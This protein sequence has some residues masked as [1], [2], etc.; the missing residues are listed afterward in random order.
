M[1]MAIYARE[2]HWSASRTVAQTKSQHLIFL[3]DTEWSVHVG[4]PWSHPALGPQLANEGLVPISPKGLCLR[5]C[6]VN[7]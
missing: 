5:Y 6:N 7:W 2:A 1:M 4:I 3:R